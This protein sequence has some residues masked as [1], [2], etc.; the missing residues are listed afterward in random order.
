MLVFVLALYL[1]VLSSFVII[2]TR[3]RALVA[4][5]FLSLD[6]LVTVNNLWFFLTVSWVGLQ[7]VIVLFLDHTHFL[8]D[9]LL[10]PTSSELTD[11]AFGISGSIY[12]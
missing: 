12:L 9:T 4:S 10:G 5:L 6:C 8:T 1:C 2:L 11:S 3:K 7:C